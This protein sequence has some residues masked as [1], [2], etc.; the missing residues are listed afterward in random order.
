MPDDPTRTGCAFSGWYTERNG[1][2]SPFTASTTVTANIT[3]YAKW[4]CTV[5]FNADGGKPVTQ[6]LTVVSGGTVGNGNMPDDPTR[7]GCAF[8]GWYTGQGG[9]GS[10]FTGS[11][12]VTES[13]TVYAK[14]LC[15][16]TFNGDAGTPAAQTRN[17][18]LGGTVGNGNMPSSPTRSG[19][20]FG[21]WY[22]ERN[23]GGSQ[24]IGSTTVTE[25]I[26]VYAKWIDLYTVTF[27]A[28]DASGTPPDGQT[29][30]AGGSVALPGQ[31]GMAR[32]GYT[33]SGWNTSADGMGTSYSAGAS[34]TPTGNVT[35][36]AQWTSDI[37]DNL[38]LNDIF[39]WISNN[40][41]EG[42][43][44]PVTLKADETIPPR[45]LSYG[46]KNV[47]VIL[48]G[49][50]TER[51]VTVNTNGS[52][53]TLENGVTLTL[54]SNIA[55]SGRSSNTAPLLRVN[56]GGTLVMDTGSRIYGNTNTNN[57]YTYTYTY[58]GG[59]YVNGGEF[60]MNGGTISGNTASSSSSSSSSPCGGGVFNAGT[61]T[62]SGGTISGNT[63]P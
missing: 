53:F 39:G 5:T 2:G 18:V 29:V 19:C 13:I 60:I 57:T 55:L 30:S 1:G 17:V 8:D 43:S 51:T 46:G 47:A 59:V 26:T 10:P 37:P 28:N 21:G 15:T 35:L 3:V 63:A 24:F 50:D 48:K 31:G 33:F 34:Y 4:S 52:L 22:T 23:G 54:G 32:P 16:V 27:N 11:T 42:G 25:S 45:T 20:A 12:T 6:A 58:G 40:A 61:F 7:T 44:Y 38:S 56:S 62:M 49:D 9:G 36:Y 41:V 14:W